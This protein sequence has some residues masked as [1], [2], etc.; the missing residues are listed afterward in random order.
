MHWTGVQLTFSS[1]I[2]IFNA[3]VSVVASVLHPYKQIQALKQGY[4]ILIYFSF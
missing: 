3:V 1:I 2:T 4:L